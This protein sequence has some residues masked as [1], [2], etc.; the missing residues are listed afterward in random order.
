MAPGRYRSHSR[1]RNCSSWIQFITR[2][3]NLQSDLLS[4]ICL[5]GAFLNKWAVSSCWWNDTS[6]RSH[7]CVTV[8]SG[9]A[10]QPHSTC[11][12]VYC[13][14]SYPTLITLDC[15]E[16]KHIITSKSCSL[17]TS[18]LVQIITMSETTPLMPPPGNT[19]QP[20]THV[21]YHSTISPA[22]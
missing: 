12:S 19:P 7:S 22:G 8:L 11:R 18:S 6:P 3:N 17:P 15:S 2:R 9:Y 13:F 14:E 1:F 4:S 21:S 5:Q 16:A 20:D 10:S